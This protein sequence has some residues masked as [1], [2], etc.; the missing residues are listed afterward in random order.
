MSRFGTRWIKY[1]HPTGISRKWNRA[2]WQQ[3][4]LYLVSTALTAQL[5]HYLRK[6]KDQQYHFTERNHYHRKPIYQP[7]CTMSL[8]YWIYER[9]ACS[10]VEICE[11]YLWIVLIWVE[12]LAKDDPRGS[13]VIWRINW[14]V[15]FCYLSNNWIA[16]LFLMKE[17]F[18]VTGY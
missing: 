6:D 8:R 12:Y 3:G 4:Y 1:E 13:F 18:P 17:N 16:S 10:W 14:N 7:M 15:Y 2:T 9:W 11:E 5:N